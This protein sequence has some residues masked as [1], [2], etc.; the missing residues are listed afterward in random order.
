[1]GREY[2]NAVLYLGWI[3]PD[4]EALLNTFKIS[5]T[6]LITVIDK[7]NVLSDEDPEVLEQYKEICQSEIWQKGDFDFLLE[8]LDE[9]QG[10]SYHN[11]LDK[12]TERIEEI[13]EGKLKFHLVTNSRAECVKLDVEDCTLLLGVKVDMNEPF[14]PDRLSNIEDDFKRIYADIA[15]KYTLI[16]P[17]FLIGVY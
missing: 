2:F 17:Q 6:E 15:E 4:I 13:L 7:H 14:S 10:Y 16:N 12:Y 9:I 5:K 3:I 1:M 8:G 11:L